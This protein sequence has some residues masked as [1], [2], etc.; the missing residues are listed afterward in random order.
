MKLWLVSDDTT[1]Y[2]SIQY[3]LCVNVNAPTARVYSRYNGQ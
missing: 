2:S 3:I 1:G